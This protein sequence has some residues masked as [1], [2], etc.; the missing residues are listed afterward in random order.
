MAEEEIKHYHTTMG[1]I[2]RMVFDG[3]IGMTINNFTQDD[4]LLRKIYSIGTFFILKMSYLRIFKS[5]HT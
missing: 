5:E 1:A 4:C 3:K 2:L